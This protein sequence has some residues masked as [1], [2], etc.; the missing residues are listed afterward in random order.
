MGSI[1]LDPASNELA[2][3]T[4][5]AARYYTA[6]GEL[7]P[8]GGNIF[9]NPPYDR[10]INLFAAKLLASDF[11]QAIFMSNSRCDTKWWQSLARTADAICFHA[12]RVRSNGSKNS[13]TCGHTFMYFCANA[14]G[15]IGQFSQYG[16]CVGTNKPRLDVGQYTISD[17]EAANKAH[18]TQFERHVRQEAA[19]HAHRNMKTEAIARPPL[20]M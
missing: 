15:F 1:D 13:P 19:Y 10:R 12:G 3:Q 11:E 18:R 20:L 8:W 9:I 2:Q 7:Q 14:D 16:W 4:V 6:D 5:Q 17:R